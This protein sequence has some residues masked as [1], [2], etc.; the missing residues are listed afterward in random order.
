M[1][2]TSSRSDWSRRAAGIFTLLVALVL[3][4]T[5][6]AVASDLLRSPDPGQGGQR[7]E[8]LSAIPGKSPDPTVD[9]RLSV[10]ATSATVGTRDQRAAGAIDTGDPTADDGYIVDGETLSPFDDHPAILNL[11]PDLRPAIRHAATDAKADG[12]E[13][14]IN[15]GW[16]SKRYQQSL[17][18]EAIVTY[19]SEKEAR[20][21]VNTPEKS[22]HVTGDAVD[23]G[24]TDADYWLI[25]HGSDYGLCQIYANEIWHFELAVEPGDT[26]PAPISDAT[27]G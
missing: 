25:Q 7:G 27:A 9:S 5:S 6:Y 19:G 15:S 20:K 17:L 10:P 22:T 2:D 4:L 14:V 21:W 24:Y 13:M 11:D 3:V 18:D 1:Q 23:V 26:C 16:R 8:S 12:V